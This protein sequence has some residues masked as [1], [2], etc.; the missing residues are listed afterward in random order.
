MPYNQT[1]TVPNQR[2]VKI[3]REP[4]KSDFLGIKNENWKSAC[5]DLRPHAF[6]LYLYFASNA[7]GYQ[8][9]LSPEAIRRE[10]GMARST[11]HD[12]FN[13]LVDKGYLVQTG[14][15]TYIFYEVPRPATEQEM[16]CPATAGEGLTNDGQTKPQAGQFYTPE[17]I[18]INKN[19]GINNIRDNY[20]TGKSKQVKEGEEKKP[21]IRRPEVKE[22]IIKEP[23]GEPKVKFPPKPERRTR[24]I[25]DDDYDFEREEQ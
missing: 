24:S 8:L 19:T 18:E 13:I 21:V 1:Y 22:I 15:N 11:Y 7:N 17:D 23:K 25:F 6:T 10:I 12:Q 2:T 4:V 3:T 16:K 20:P 9:A 5:R 14:G